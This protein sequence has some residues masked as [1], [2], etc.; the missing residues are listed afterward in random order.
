MRYIQTSNTPTTA[1]R[2]ISEGFSGGIIAGITHA[3]D[4]SHD[5]SVARGWWANSKG[6]PQD[7]NVGEMFA[8]MH[9]EIS[10]AL[11]AARK[12]TPSTHI[13]GFTGVEEE[14][15]DLLVRVFDFA[16]GAGLRLSEAFKARCLFNLNRPDHS[17]E[18]R[19][20]PGGKSF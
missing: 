18:V 20:A 17:A 3:V 1:N 7:R 6:E 14:L 15:A 12:D 16:G 2:H 13:P 8:L 4:I 9:S 10:E 19:N 5:I 11:E